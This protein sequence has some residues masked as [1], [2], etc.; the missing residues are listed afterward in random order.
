M[1]KFKN[2]KYVT[3]VSDSISCNNTTELCDIANILF[4]RLKRY[5]EKNH[6]LKLISYNIYMIMV[7]VIMIG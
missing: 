3:W 4:T 1:I 7:V 5:I 6:N 2:K